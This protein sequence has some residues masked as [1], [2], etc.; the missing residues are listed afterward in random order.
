MLAVDL[1]KLRW[2]EAT[3]RSALIKELAVPTSRQVK[4]KCTVTKESAS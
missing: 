1:Q 3:P 2:N 4:E